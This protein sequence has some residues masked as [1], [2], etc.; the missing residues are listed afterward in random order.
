MPGVGSALRKGHRRWRQLTA[1]SF[2]WPRWLF[3]SPQLVGNRLFFISDLSG[4]LSLYAMDCGGSVPEPLLPRDIAVQNPILMDGE[5]FFVF[6]G[7]GLVLVMIDR[8]GDENYQPAFVPLD[9]GMPEYRFGDRFAGQQVVCVH[10]DLERNLA[11]FVVDS[12]QDAERRSYLADLGT[13]EI[14]DLGSSLYGNY[15]VGA[16]ADYSK[17]IL[18]DTYT[19]ADDVLFLWRRGEDG[20]KL[21]FG[22]P[23]DERAPGEAVPLTGFRDCSLYRRR[24]WFAFCDSA[25]RRSLRS[26]LPE[27]G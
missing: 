5:S 1:W 10:A 9:G 6:P 16:N 23:L 11:V 14:T 3:L 18:A 2:C 26:G 8:D 24:Q 12:R 4:R 13:F 19:V 22:K 25:V 7:L 21:L 17:I 27:H 20:R 15:Y